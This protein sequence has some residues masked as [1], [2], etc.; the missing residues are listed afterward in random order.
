M[1]RS[2]IDENKKK[3][4]KKNVVKSYEYIIF[5]SCRGE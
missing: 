3:K 4:K 5:L 1:I 2:F